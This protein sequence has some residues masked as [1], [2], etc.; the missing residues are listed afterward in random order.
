MADEDKLL[1]YEYSAFV[2]AHT[3]PESSAD[4]PDLLDRLIAR[5]QA[6]T[7]KDEPRWEL[8]SHD[9]LLNGGELVATFFIRRPKNE[10][11]RSG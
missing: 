2:L 9:F 1:E 4:W 10:S 5:V 6:T 7:E 8:V 3:A 11:A